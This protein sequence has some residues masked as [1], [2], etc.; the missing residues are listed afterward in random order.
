[1]IHFY[2]ELEGCIVHHLCIVRFVNEIGAE[3][4]VQ[5]CTVISGKILAKSIIYS[6]CFFN[7]IIIVTKFVHSKI[8]A[9][10]T[11]LQHSKVLFVFFKVQ[12]NW[13]FGGHFL[14]GAIPVQVVTQDFLSK[15][16]PDP[17]FNQC[18]IPICTTFSIPSSLRV[19]A[20]LPK[21]S[22]AIN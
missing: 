22:R 10:A 2:V 14:R 19:W 6:L 16:M 7:Y 4:C 12:L 1:M 17:K 5:K 9:T 8:H 18:H 21:N 3:R 20:P 11:G 13:T 15:D